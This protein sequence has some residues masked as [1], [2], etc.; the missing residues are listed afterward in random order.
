VPTLTP[1]EG[2]ARAIERLNDC[3]I[4]S[5]LIHRVKALQ[6]FWLPRPPEGIAEGQHWQLRIGGLGAGRR[7]RAW[8]AERGRLL[9]EISTAP[10]VT[11]V[12]LVVPPEHAVR[13][14]QL[15]L[16][17]TPLMEQDEYLREA[18][19]VVPDQAVTGASLVVRQTPL[20][21]APVSG[22]LR[23]DDETALGGYSLGQTREAWPL[24][25]SEAGVH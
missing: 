24:A 21:R 12:S 18:S 14:L 5:S 6:V 25:G 10:E 13:T 15:T 4:F 11:E 19:S 2:Q 3:K 16:D 20:L 1:A 23:A 9:S 7:L 8:D 17:E 22:L